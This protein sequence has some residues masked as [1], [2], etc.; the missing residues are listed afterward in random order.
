MHNIKNEQTLKGS[1]KIWQLQ[2]KIKTT[3]EQV[4]SVIRQ[5]IISGKIKPGAR[6]MEASISEQLGVS[7]SPIREAVRILESEELI[8]ITPNKGVS[9]T[10]LNE[11]DLWEIYELRIL[12][13]SYGMRRVCKTITEEQLKELRHIIQEMEKMKQSKDHLGYLKVSHEFHEFYIKRCNNERLFN[14]FRVLKNGIFAIQIFS[15]S[16]SDFLD[17]SLREHRKIFL[18]LLKRDADGAELALKNHLK[19]GYERAKKYLDKK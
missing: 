13:E 11:K 16:Y 2:D 18:K 12:L 4:A 10:Q 19:S 9:V 5:A 15:Y 17:D 8:R 14:L 3:S 7:R 6:I 1:Q